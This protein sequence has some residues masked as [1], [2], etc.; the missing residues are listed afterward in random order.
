MRQDLKS[1]DVVQED[2]QAAART[3]VLEPSS[4]VLVMVVITNFSQELE[5]GR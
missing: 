4:S 3:I 5:S 1:V 2:R